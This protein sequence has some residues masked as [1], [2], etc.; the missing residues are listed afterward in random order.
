MRVHHH[1]YIRSPQARDVRISV[2]V[3]VIVGIS[4]LGSFSSVFIVE[5]EQHRT[6]GRAGVL[7]LRMKIRYS[8][9]PL[10]ER[11]GK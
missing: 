5:F 8:P 6:V 1:N 4:W 10:L 9:S 3:L 2:A 11:G 7:A